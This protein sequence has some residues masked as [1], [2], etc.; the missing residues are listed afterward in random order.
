MSHRCFAAV[1]TVITVV[2]LAPVFAAAQSTGPLRTSWGAP[3]SRVSGT[4]A[5]SHPSS[6]LK[7]WATRRFLPRKRRRTSHKKPLT[8][9]NAC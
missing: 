9:T 7:S 6:G 8:G 1:F 4:T 5:P 3:I 2:A